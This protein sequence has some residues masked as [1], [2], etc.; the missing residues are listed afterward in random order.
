MSQQSHPTFGNG[1]ICYIELPAIDITRSAEFYKAV[2]GW[3]VRQNSDGHTSFDDG[4][5]EVSGTWVT[6][7]SP[8]KAGGLMV[9]IMVDDMEATIAAVI[10]HGGA[11]TAPPGTDGPERYAQFSDPAGNILGLHQQAG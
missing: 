8:A 2:F 4:V 10:A 5:G 6:D 1:K 7:R 11:I 3:N 9:H